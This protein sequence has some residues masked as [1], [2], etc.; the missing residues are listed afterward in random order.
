VTGRAAAPR[1]TLAVTIVG[2]LVA[3]ALTWAPTQILWACHVASFVIAIGLVADVPKLIAIGLV[4]HAGQG[5]PAWLLD[6]F[7]IGEYSV[8]STLLHVVPIASCLWALWPKPLPR[9]ILLPAWLL[10][11]LAMVLAYFLSDPK[12]NVMLVH[13]PYGLAAAWF[14][15]MWMSHVFNIALSLLCCSI[16]W[17]VLR[18]VIWRN[19]Q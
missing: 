1:I 3:H 12:L 7:V 16:G 4:F 9:G 18:F 15:A 5:I 17:L 19:R 13:E 6:L 2:L 11:P 14:D 8:T 10:Q